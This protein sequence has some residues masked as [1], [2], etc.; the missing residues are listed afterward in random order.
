MVKGFIGV[1]NERVEEVQRRVYKKIFTLT[2]GGGKLFYVGEIK[3]G[4]GRSKDK[5]GILYIYLYFVSFSHVK[6]TT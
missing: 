1:P 3:I 2:V 4:K 5:R 6:S